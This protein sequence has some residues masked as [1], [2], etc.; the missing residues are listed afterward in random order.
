MLGVLAGGGEV[1]VEE[2]EGAIWGRSGER[3]GGA[4]GKGSKGSKAPKDWMRSPLGLGTK[5]SGRELRRD[6]SVSLSPPYRSPMASVT[7]WLSSLI[8]I[9]GTW[10][11]RIWYMRSSSRARSLAC[12]GQG[13]VVSNRVGSSGGAG[14]EGVAARALPRP[15][16]RPGEAR[17]RAC[18]AIRRKTHHHV[19]P[20]LQC[21][22]MLVGQLPR[23]LPVQQNRPQR[24]AS[25]AERRAARSTSRARARRAGSAGVWAAAE[26]PFMTTQGR[27]HRV[28]EM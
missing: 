22:E 4:A 1:E 13:R 7:W 15:K 23:R 6:V 10:P 17:R 21:A 19:C 5:L 27:F 28:L 18:A 3:A 24:R 11:R 16:P 20:S 9:C 2:D 12:S 25:N 14:R 8:E 26:S